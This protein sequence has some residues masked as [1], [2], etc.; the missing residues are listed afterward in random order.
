MDKKNSPL[1]FQLDI[2]SSILFS[3]MYKTDKPWLL[4]P[5]ALVNIICCEIN[6]WKE[7]SVTL[8]AEKFENKLDI[9]FHESDFCEKEKI[10]KRKNVFKKS[11]NICEHLCL[12][13]ILDGTLC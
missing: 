8:L 6:N 1:C 4:W 3:S 9:F 11:K 7:Y 12:R 2:F 10:G 5:W 13:T